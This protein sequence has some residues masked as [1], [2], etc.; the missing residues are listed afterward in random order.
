MS[1][2]LNGILTILGIAT[3]L[4][5]A[6]TPSHAGL[7]LGKLFRADC[8][9]LQH[10]VHGVGGPRDGDSRQRMA[11]WARHPERHNRRFC[12]PAA[13]EAKVRDVVRD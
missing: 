8:P 1:K 9:A 5:F 11:N 3:L 13:R 2:V 12:D 7:K 10:Q 4:M 6:A